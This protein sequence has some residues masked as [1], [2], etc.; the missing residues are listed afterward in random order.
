MIHLFKGKGRILWF[1]KGWANSVTRWI[2]G[3]HSSD[4][5]IETKN[6]ANPDDDGSLDLK[7]S[8][9]YLVREVE[10]HLGTRGLT[11]YEHQRVKDIIHGA[12]DGVSLKWTGAHAAV[13]TDWLI[14]IVKKNMVDNENVHQ[15]K[16]PTS[17]TPMPSGFSGV[18][19]D[20]T[21]K[22]MSTKTF[23]KATEPGLKIKLCC[24]GADGGQNGA[25]FWREFIIAGDGRIYSISGE[26]D[27]MG[28]YTDQ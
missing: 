24:R 20:Y 7:V 11:K 28:M 2:L 13:D 23:G 6:T 19:G 22:D 27:A 4:G 9:S 15:V 26:C 5:S 12:L 21:T 16:A 25:V 10:K 14:D 1:Q 3:I 18:G 8:R 17:T